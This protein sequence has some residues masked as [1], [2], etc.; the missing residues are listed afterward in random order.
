MKPTFSDE[1]YTNV[2]LSEGMEFQSVELVYG[3]PAYTHSI[4][5]SSAVATILCALPV[6]SPVLQACDV[7]H[8][9]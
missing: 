8:V 4:A 1:V 9:V 7:G 6:C 5:R 3:A 2:G